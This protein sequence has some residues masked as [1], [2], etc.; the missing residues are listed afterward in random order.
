MGRISTKCLLLFSYFST[1]SLVKIHRSCK[2][3]MQVSMCNC[4]HH[5]I[6]TVVLFIFSQI[7][8]SEKE[9]FLHECSGHL[10]VNHGFCQHNFWGMSLISEKYFF[11]VEFFP[12]CV[13]WFTI[14]KVV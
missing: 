7:F 9:R 8:C 11:Y 13:V 2:L 12:I 6:N 4:M 5:K 3:H 1:M 10:E 14:N